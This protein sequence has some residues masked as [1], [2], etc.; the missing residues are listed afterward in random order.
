MNVK[1][2]F[3]LLLHFVA[4]LIANIIAGYVQQ[5]VLLNI[6]TPQR[7]LVGVIFAL[8]MLALIT[9]L[10]NKKD[11]VWNWRWHRFWY[12]RG[13]LNNRKFEQ[14]KID[15]NRLD[16]SQGKRRAPR[17]DV[18]VDGKPKD[19]IKV[20]KRAI[21]FRDEGARIIILGEPGSGKTTCLKKLTF[22]LANVGKKQLWNYTPI[23]IPVE[24]GNFKNVKLEEHI[25]KTLEDSTTDD[26]GKVLSKGLDLLMRWGHIVL[27]FDALDETPSKWRDE[28]LSGLAGYIEAAAFSKMPII[29]TTRTREDPGQRLKNKQVY[30]IQELSDESINDFVALYKHQN[31]SINEIITQLK[32]HKMLDNGGLGRNPFWLRRIIDSRIFNGSKGEILNQSVDYL[33]KREVDKPDSE[34]Y[35]E[36]KLDKSEQIKITKQGL[37][38][39]GFYLW[40]SKGKVNCTE[41]EALNEIARWIKTQTGLEK[42]RPQDILGLGNDAQIL[43]YYSPVIQF[44]HQL[45]QDFMIAWAISMEKDLLDKAESKEDKLKKKLVNE[46]LTGII[47]DQNSNIQK[48]AVEALGKIGDANV[49]ESLINI[50]DHKD[51]EIQLEAKNALIKLGKK[52]VLNR[53][54]INTL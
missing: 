43:Y 35:W 5:D 14:V 24:L 30:K 25:K 7:I 53:K 39:L 8:L 38:I 50:L 33:L 48:G 40:E 21:E 51:N 49:V 18:L 52:K 26:S 3:I 10:K 46:M 45:L 9:I 44:R 32:K 17:I 54:V 23:P 2:F 16:S 37:A 36:R 6:F 42:I 27:L 31:D 19:L 29:I 34:R 47:K 41:K 11:L 28:V 20:L 15:Y 4:G 12:F 1:N 13:L 22:D